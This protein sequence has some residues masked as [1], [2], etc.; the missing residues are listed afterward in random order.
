MADKIVRLG[1]GEIPPPGKV[2]ATLVRFLEDQ[3][4]RAR[5][6]DII[7]FAGATLGSKHQST[8]WFAGTVGTFGMVGALECAKRKVMAVAMGDDE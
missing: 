6:G 3:L 8:F 7:G 2:D 4:E 5:S 1:G